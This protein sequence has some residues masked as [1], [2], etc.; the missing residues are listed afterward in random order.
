MLASRTYRVYWFFL[1]RWCPPFCSD[2]SKTCWCPREKKAYPDLLTVLITSDSGI[3]HHEYLLAGYD[4]ILRSRVR[5]RW[6]C[7]CQHNLRLGIYDEKTSLYDHCWLWCYRWISNSVS[8]IVLRLNHQRL[9]GMVRNVRSLVSLD[10]TRNVLAPR[11]PWLS[12]C[13]GKIRWSKAGPFKNGEI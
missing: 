2:N 10:C 1:L 5:L 11:I 7:L 12:I 3:I 9:E 8:D 13:K 6:Q 4:F